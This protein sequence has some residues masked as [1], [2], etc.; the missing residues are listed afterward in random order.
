MHTKKGIFSNFLQIQLCVF[1]FNNIS[2]I[3]NDKPNKIYILIK[4]THIIYLY[5][6]RQGWCMH[7]DVKGLFTE[8]HGVIDV[9]HSLSSNGFIAFGGSNRYLLKDYSAPH[10]LTCWETQAFFWPKRHK[11]FRINNGPVAVV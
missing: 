10:P 3:I 9:L 5:R 11:L 4:W 6:D 2:A 1:P 7:A 8:S